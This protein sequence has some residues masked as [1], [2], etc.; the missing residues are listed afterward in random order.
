MDILKDLGVTAAKQ[1]GGQKSFYDQTKFTIAG[2]KVMYAKELGIKVKNPTYKDNPYFVFKLES[3]NGD[4]FVQSQMLFLLETGEV[5]SPI[6]SSYTKKTGKY[7]PS[8]MTYDI[9]KAIEDELNEQDLKDFKEL[10]WTDDRKWVGR[11]FTMGLKSGE[12]D[13]KKWY[14]LETDDRKYMDYLGMYHKVHTG[15][16]SNDRYMLVETYDK[17]EYPND[18]KTYHQIEEEFTAG[19]VN[20]ASN[21][22]KDPK[23]MDD[24]AKEVDKDLPF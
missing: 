5:R 9:K 2:V 6:A 8:S 19:V 24:F 12:K 18:M 4:K 11:V 15:D 7:G 14:M 20:D 13:D 23:A 21:E 10:P 3:E 1:E 22:V 17:G 16:Y